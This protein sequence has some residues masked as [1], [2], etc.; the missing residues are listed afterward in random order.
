MASSQLS[1]T[2][3]DYQDCMSMSGL[4]GASNLQQPDGPQQTRSQRSNSSTSSLTFR[5]VLTFDPTQPMRDHPNSSDRGALTSQQ[6]TWRGRCMSGC[7]GCLMACRGLFGRSSPSNPAVNHFSSSAPGTHGARNDTPLLRQSDPPELAPGL[8]QEALMVV[9]EDEEVIAIDGNPAGLQRLVDVLVHNIGVDALEDPEKL[10]PKLRMPY[11]PPSEFTSDFRKCVRARMTANDFRQMMYILE[12]IFQPLNTLTSLRT[13]MNIF[14][15]QWVV[16]IRPVAM[17]LQIYKSYNKTARES[18]RIA[19]TQEERENS[20]KYDQQYRACNLRVL[21]DA[22]NDARVA[23]SDGGPLSE[24]AVTWTKCVI[25]FMCSI[26]NLYLQVCPPN[27]YSI[28]EYVAWV[29]ST[30]VQRSLPQPH[31]IFGDSN[32][33]KTLPWYIRGMVSTALRAARIGPVEIFNASMTEVFGDSIEV[34]RRFRD[35]LRAMTCILDMVLECAAE[36]SE[37]QRHRYSEGGGSQTLEC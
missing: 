3:G 7:A 18:A 28:R 27:I 29:E 6:G 1:F 20:Y 16:K 30:G 32:L 5:S 15:N 31:R 25:E 33:H 34:V 17:N 8:L 13:V 12:S 21:M 19:L 24:Q 23:R 11:A 35:N 2:V 22:D 4:S 9:E 36:C 10:G 37:E 26:F 14:M